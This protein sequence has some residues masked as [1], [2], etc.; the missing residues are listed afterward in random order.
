MHDLRSIETFVA[1]ATRGSFRGAAT[2][3]NT[4]QPAVSQRIAQLE[5]EVGARLIDRTSRHVRLTEAGR[6][7]L[8]YAER[9]LALG[10]EMRRAARGRD[11]VAGTLRLGCSETI[12]HAWLSAFIAR[13]AIEHPGLALDIEVDT[14]P[15]LTSALLAQQLD[16][17]FM[18]GPSAE[19]GISNVPLAR[20]RIGFL[21]SPHLGLPDRL[22]SRD[23]LAARTLITF[24]R[25]TQPY[26][27]LRAAF[28]GANQTMPR[29]HACASLAPA[30][31]LAVDGVG[32]AVVPPVVARNEMANGVLR[33]VRTDI[34]VPD[35]D[36]VAAYVNGRSSRHASAVAALAREV[37]GAGID[38]ES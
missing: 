4:T 22:L 27:A 11:T 1:V 33:Q 12:V 14:T 37:A 10:S 35:L 16:L 38:Q 5:R 15:N 28:S 20:Y 7:A 17:A 18:L 26:A 24:A 21:A 23:D 36:F 30:V 32:I 9:I 19:P 2:V 8:A 6:E 25:R 31:R 13:L 3:L 29:L 34:E